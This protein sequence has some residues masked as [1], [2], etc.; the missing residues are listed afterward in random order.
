M[1]YSDFP[2]GKIL[3]QQQ[4]FFLAGQSKTLTSNVVSIGIVCAV[5]GRELECRRFQS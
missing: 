5:N 1:A 2:G 4:K 3:S